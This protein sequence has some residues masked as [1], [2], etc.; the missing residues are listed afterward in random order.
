M[1]FLYFDKKIYNLHWYQQITG[2]ILIFV[3]HIVSV[4]VSHLLKS[5]YSSLPFIAF[6][7]IPI[8]TNTNISAK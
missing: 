3:G 1:I 7:L 5:N 6:R 2:D 8:Y 4:D